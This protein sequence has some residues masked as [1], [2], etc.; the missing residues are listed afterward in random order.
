MAPTSSHRRCLRSSRT[1]SS[2]SVSRLSASTGTSNYNKYFSMVSVGPDGVNAFSR[3]FFEIAIDQKPKPETVAILAAD[4]EFA[5]SAADGARDE[6][7]KHGLN[8]VY[9]QSYPPQA[10]DFSAVMRAVRAANADLV[11]IGAYP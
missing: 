3:G 11:W 2:R 1:T 8:L 10:T 7:K 4:A 6:I 9:D 5:R